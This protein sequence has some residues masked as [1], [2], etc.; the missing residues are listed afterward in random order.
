MNPLISIIVPVYNVEEYLD[1][2]VD[3]IVNQTYKELEIFLVDDGSPDNCPQMCDNWAKK[4]NRI[5]VIHKENG[6]L[7]DARNAALDVAT[8]KYVFFVDS[9]DAIAEN[10]I[11]LL[12]NVA[13]EKHSSVVI[14]NYYKTFSNDFNFK[15]ASINRIETVDSIIALEKVFCENSRWEA[16]GTLY[17]SELFSE[18]RYPFGK[19][20]EDISTMPKIL[21]KSEIVSFVDTTVYYYFLRQDSIMRKNECIVK[22]DLLDA[23]VEIWSTIGCIKDSHIVNAQAGVLSELSSRIHVARKDKNSNIQFINDSIRFIKKN[24]R[25]IFK[26][27]KMSIKQKVFIVLVLLNLSNRIWR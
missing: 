1:R 18:I 10:A 14:S 24:I 17:R 19:I 12:L 16:W 11:E 20:Y 5:K 13:I 15:K 7:S 23:V 2:C 27:N 26:S 6:G 22:Y 25:I 21:L 4:D 8:G 9:D 3:S